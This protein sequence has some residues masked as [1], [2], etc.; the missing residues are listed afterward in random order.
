[1]GY[2]QFPSI[3]RGTARCQSVWMFRNMDGG[4]AKVG[5]TKA[6]NGMTTNPRGEEIE[7]WSLSCG[8]SYSSSDLLL[9]AACQ[10]IATLQVPKRLYVLILGTACSQT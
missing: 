4:D 1:M 3:G 10:Q 8:T 2:G 6:T 7:L 5:D 9:N